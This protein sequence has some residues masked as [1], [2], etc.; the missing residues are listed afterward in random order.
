M[1]LVT[2]EK[3]FQILHDEVA[4][5]RGNEMK[6]LICGS[7]ELNDFVLYKGVSPIF[8]GR[9]LFECDNCSVRQLAKMIT[10]EEAKEYNSN[11]W[12]KISGFYNSQTEEKTRWKRRVLAK[13]RA[14]YLSDWLLSDEEVLEAGSERGYLFDELRKR[15]LGRSFSSI[16]YDEG[17]RKALIQKNIGCYFSKEEIGRKKFDIIILAHV[18]EHMVDLEGFLVWAKNHLK[19]FGMVFIDVPSNDDEFRLMHEPHLF[20]FNEQVMRKLASDLG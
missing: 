16:E 4:A 13:E 6:C 19:L 20:V 10:E 17:M 11:Y 14:K 15:N 8:T 1:Q 3:V 7:D 5:K 2:H 9:V 12:D 18:L